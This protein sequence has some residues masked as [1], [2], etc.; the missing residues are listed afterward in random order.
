MADGVRPLCEHKKTR[1]LAVMVSAG[2]ATVG[3]RDG[4]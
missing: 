3:G 4:L 1:F 2:V